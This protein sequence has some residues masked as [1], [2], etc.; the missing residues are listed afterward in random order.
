MTRLKHQL[1]VNALAL[2]IAAPLSAQTPAPGIDFDLGID[3]RAIMDGLA[4]APKSAGL[5]LVQFRE[6]A[7]GL[8]LAFQDQQAESY[9][10]G[11]TRLI[12][13]VKEDLGLH[14][15]PV[16]FDIDI[17]QPVGPFYE[18]SFKDVLRK[19]HPGGKY[20]AVWSFQRQGPDGTQAVRK[21]GRSFSLV[22][23]DT[24]PEA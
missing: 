13:E 12:I 2:L 18:F 23:A 21:G 7:V 3:M 16:I 8:T 20:Y 19:L 5:A 17:A 15:D 24:Q 14:P 11:M 4:P 6:D 1:V 10:G 22:L 9:A